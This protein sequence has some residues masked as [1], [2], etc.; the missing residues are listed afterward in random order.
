MA[1][2]RRIFNLLT[3]SKVEREIDAELRSHIAM[4]IED[5]IASGMAPKEAR[6]D[7]LVRFGNP[8]VMRERT[9]ESD[10][11]LYLE[12][13]VA[14]IR[15][16]WR[17]L[18][19]APAF[20]LT[21]VVILALGIGASTAIFTAIKP[22]LLDPLPYP[23]ANRITT[24]W[25]KS[26]DV[27]PRDVTFSTFHGLSERSHTWGALAVM[28]PWQPAMVATAQNVEPERLEGQRVSA[29]FFRALG[30]P[31]LLGRD[32][33]AA[34][35]RFHGP[36]VVILSDRL[37]RKRFGADRSII[38]EQVR[39]DDNLFTVIGVMPAAFED[40][41]QPTAELWAPLQYD[42]SLPADGREWGHHLRMIG[43]LLPGVGRDQAISEAD[44]ILQTLAQIYAKGYDSSG[45]APKGMIVNPLQQEITRSVRPALLSVL[46]AALLLMLIACVNV[47]NLL[48]ARGAQRRSEFAMRV[49]LGAG[50]GR[51]IRQL[52]TE[53]LLLALLAGAL[54]MGVA[55]AGVRAL[56]ALSPAGLPRVSAISVDGI[57]FSFALGISALIGM[58]VGLVPA[59]TA[60][61]SRLAQ[62]VQQSSRRTV[63][64][65][66]TRRALVVAEVSLAVMLLVSTGLL[67]RSMQCL[68][69]VD[70]G[71]DATNLL[72]MQVQES[73]HR[74]HSDAVG[75][76]VFDQ[77]LERVRE[78]PGVITAG[79]TSQLPLS[80]DL[81]IYGV[82]FEHG[83]AADGALRYAVTPGYLEAMHIPLLRGRL[84]NDSDIAGAPTAVLINDS[85]AKRIFSGANQTGP[86][87]PIGQ[88]IRLWPDM[89]HGDRP[90]ATIVGVVG[91]VKQTSLAVGNEDAFYVTTAQWAWTDNVQ[92]LVIRIKGPA[93]PLTSAIRN[94][95]W[96]V[97]RDLP[98]VR[99]TTMDALLA[100]SES[101]RRFVLLL[102]EAF[103]L[104]GLALAATGIYGMLSGSVTE[105]TREIGVRAALGASRS[106]IVSLILRQGMTLTLLGILIGLA[107]AMIASRGLATLLFG[108]T[109]LD[110]L[111]Y[112][113]VS[114]LLSAISAFACFAPALRAAAVDPV[115]ALR[116]E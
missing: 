109:P 27:T 47:T 23:D 100:T 43:R 33:Q 34:D 44:G 3:R 11:A 16:A 68:F 41:L 108:V 75:L 83:P 85:Y 114:L 62:R 55:F 72:T 90:W 106:S 40:V 45:G 71:F 96:S 89:G 32:F 116:A 60:S 64:S 49:A 20:A 53:S 39:L 86:I 63:G 82:Q 14:D 94:A 9:T 19:S 111:T 76:Q 6:R 78:I 59:L 115:E 7:A 104:V 35:D 101:Q 88:R 84:L 28:K 57:V 30:I 17:Q 25:E 77:V 110:P 105:R 97:D 15:Y 58:G 1:L 74:F 92:T 79:S 21:S 48:L 99:I 93:A 70:P 98:I 2:V 50:K 36:A 46:G 10:A 24:L 107:A 54:G 4:R 52:L 91:D 73:G 12:S 22:I 18:R 56:V 66:F 31:P 87:N 69:A 8:T 37:W 42:P 26:E 113:A 81:D 5:N 103:A 67:L 80:G 65:H 112:L 61:R 51:L 95:I 102:L 13:I 38:G 29:E